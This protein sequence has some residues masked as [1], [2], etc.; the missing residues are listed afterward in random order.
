[1]QEGAEVCPN[2]L[3]TDG[4]FAITK[5]KGQSRSRH[6][7]CFWAALMIIIIT[8]ASHTGKTALA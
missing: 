7:D 3:T 8:D 1:M 4:R 2:I 6:K 5:G